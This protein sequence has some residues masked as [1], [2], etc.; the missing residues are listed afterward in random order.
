MST[1]YTLSL[2]SSAA[3]KDDV[4]PLLGHKNLWRV[5]CGEKVVAYCV[6]K[7]L[8]DRIAHEDLYR[9]TESGSGNMFAF[10]SLD[11]PVALCIGTVN[12][13]LRKAE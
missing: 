1:T 11:A 3:I 6:A 4:G 12:A 10:P 5:E 7:D 8:A 13:L 2:I 9:V